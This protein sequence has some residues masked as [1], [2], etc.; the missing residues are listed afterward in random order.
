MKNATHHLN[1]KTKSDKK[2]LIHKNS[3]EKNKTDKEKET[4][5]ETVKSELGKNKKYTDH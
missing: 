2:K 1:L 3:E 5:L 4:L